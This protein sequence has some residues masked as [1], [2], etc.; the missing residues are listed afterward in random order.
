MKWIGQHI[1]GFISRFRNDVY[2]EDIS[3][4]TIAS[5]SNLGLDA[6]NKIVKASASGGIAFDG[7]TANGVLTYKDSDEATVESNLTFDGS[8][9]SLTGD[10][11]VEGDTITLQ[12][13]NADDPKIVIQNNTNDAQGA[14]LQ[15]KKNRGAAQVN[16]DN[17]AEMDFFGE[18]A[19]QNQAQYAKMLVRA[20]EVTD[21]QESGDFRIQVAAHDATLTQG[22]KLVGGSQSGEVDVTV[23]AGTASV[24]TVEGTLTMGSTAFA[25]NSGVVQVATQGTI[26]HDSLANFVANE[27]IDWTT[28]QGSTNIHSGNYTNTTYSEATSSDAGLMST[29]HH[30]KLDGIETSADVTDATNVTAA[31]ALMDSE[32]SSLASVKALDQGVATGD[33]PQ[34]AGINLGHANDTT[35]ARSASGTATI[36][37]KEIVTRDKVIYIETAN[38]SDDIN[39]DAHYIPFVTTG[40]HI[41]FAN[42]AVPFVA[43]APGKLLGVHFKAN[44]HTDTS[45]NTV[46]FRLDRLDDGQLWSSGNEATIGTKVVDG[47]NRVNTCSADFT[48]LTTAGASGTNAFDADEMIGVSLQNS[49]N[50]TSTKYSVTLVFE[51]DFSSYYS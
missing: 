28:D 7:S 45:S 50:F 5:G 46:T 20:N 16:N 4:G 27:H 10:L 6:N 51:F 37:G 48:D 41:S 3:S 31:G 36:E 23:G 47:V 38:F 29:T 2:L 14:R 8:T 19:G 13:D 44:N 22:L 18:D 21:G 34:F 40:E 43:P 26:D 15:M 42:V 24:T 1:W 35:F 49:V 32:C 30:D 25:N 11:T 12:S 33:S 39:T 9:L 17:V